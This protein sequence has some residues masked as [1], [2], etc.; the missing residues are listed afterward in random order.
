M[1]NIP[2]TFLNIGEKGTVK[3]IQGND[4][5]A[6]KLYEMGINKGSN[7]EIVKNDLG[8]LIVSLTGSRIAISKSLAQKILISKR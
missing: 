6:K 3:N 8:P 2:L 5:I 7:I 1:E 4:T